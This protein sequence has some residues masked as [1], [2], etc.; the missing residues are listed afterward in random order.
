MEEY[1]PEWAHAL[2][3]LNRE[4]GEYHV[5]AYTPRGHPAHHRESREH[6]AAV[7]EWL[8]DTKPPC[9]HMNEEYVMD[10]RCSKC[11]EYVLR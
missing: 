8:H 2:I 9:L 4:T 11:G 7:K 6:Q 5:D 3:H 1:G 10:G